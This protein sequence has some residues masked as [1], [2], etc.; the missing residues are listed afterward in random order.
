MQINY[1]Q[2]YDYNYN[3]SS[4]NEIS[5]Q[6][7]NNYS[8][9][10]EDIITINDTKKCDKY[11]FSK[12]N[13]NM[14]TYKKEGKSRE[15]I[16]KYYDS[17]L[18]QIENEFKFDYNCLSISD[19]EEN[20]LFETDLITIIL[21]TLINE[22][23][24]SNKN[25]TAIDFGKC[26]SIL[27]KFY[28][29]AENETLYLKKV[30]IKQEGMKIPKIEYDIYHK[31]SINNLKKLNLSVCEDTP[32]YI[33]M[34]IEIVESLDI[35]NSSSAYYNDICYTA[36]SESGTDIILKDRRNEFIEKNKTICQDDCDF[37][38]YNYNTKKS[39]CSCKIQESSLSFADMNINKTKLLNN[40]RNI[41][42]FINLDILKCYKVLFTVKG[43]IFN[44][45]CFIIIA[46]IIFDI[47]CIVIFIKKDL[48]IIQDKINKIYS[49]IICH[50]DVKKTEDLNINKN[51]EKCKEIT[52]VNNNIISNRL[53]IEKDKKI[54]KKKNIFNKKSISKKS[55]LKPIKLQK[56]KG[57][58]DK[59]IYTSE[60]INSL[61]Y[62][63]ALLYDNRTYCQ[64]YIS[65][66][67]TKHNFI[68]SFFN[69]N[70]YNSRIIKI[71][72]FFVGFT[73]YYAINA[74]F[75]T[76]NTMHKIY[77]SMGSYEF[78]NQITIVVSSSLISVILNTILKILALSNDDIIEF[79]Q[80]EEK[81]NMIEK[82]NNL[83]KK[84]HL[85]FTLYFII[86]FILLLFIWYYISMFGAIYRN[87][88]YHLLK[89]TLMGFGLSLIYPF[90]IYLLPGIFRILSLS[91]DKNK[92]KKKECLYKFSCILQKI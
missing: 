61:K 44:I 68:F 62:N 75:Y 20:L 76:D 92:K 34:P 67:K 55:I 83:F 56:K 52:S 33:T 57:T 81:E 22:K 66:L 29:I 9:T 60:E 48:S 7:T 31:L 32:I 70:D 8:S 82:K 24:N 3:Y 85:K 47:I 77:E 43:I 53:P 74:L 40:F 91:V 63:L 65:L 30:Y 21:T 26:E 6:S 15:E 72:F 90:V 39:K 4:D 19:S 54:S 25:I 49:S 1:Y 13:E 64:Y 50:N 12:I 27:R 86:S 28:N 51:K 38:E 73:I 87:T 59:N 80:K 46:I 11:N 41:K 36:K 42:N 35:L 45:G 2:N 16:I 14:E 71:N 18:A 79:K 10:I 5:F 78:E 88:Q 58:S 23:K 17:V 84:L 89:D 69:N 37:T